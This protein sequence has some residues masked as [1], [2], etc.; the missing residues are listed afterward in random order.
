MNEIN[1]Y[2][3]DSKVLVVGG[4]GFIGRNLVESLK[5]DAGHICVMH[6]SNS[7]LPFDHANIS[8]LIHDLSS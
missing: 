4:T 7:E 2:F 1:K 5:D 8:N 6:L 3:H